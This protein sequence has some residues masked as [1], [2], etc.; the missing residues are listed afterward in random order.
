MKKLHIGCEYTL[1]DG[2]INADNVIPYNLSDKDKA[3]VFMMDASLKFPFED[4]SLDYI[5]SEHLIEH[6]FYSGFVNYINESYRCLKPGGV[7]RTA[8]PKLEFYIDLYLHPELY[9]DYLKNHYER[10]NYRMIRE[11]GGADNIPPVFCINDNFKMWGHKILYDVPTLMKMF[12]RAGFK[13][14]KECKYGIS[15]HPDLNDLEHDN[16]RGREFNMLETGIIECTK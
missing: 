12:E 2:W 4:N 10:F 7:I 11:W 9:K 14:I 16:K 6:L 8:C 5:Y 1:M 3:R 15:E 13:D